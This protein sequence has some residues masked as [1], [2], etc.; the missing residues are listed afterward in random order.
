[1]EVLKK[2]TFVCRRPQSDEIAEELTFSSEVASS[3]P[4]LK[5][6][7][8]GLLLHGYLLVYLLST[9][10][11]VL[12][13]TPSHRVKMEKEVGPAAPDL[14]S[15]GVPP[16]ESSVVQRWKQN[17]TPTHA[18]LICLLLT[19]LTGLCDS[20]AYNA[21]SCFLGMQTGMNHRRSPASRKGRKVKKKKRKKAQRPRN[22]H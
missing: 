18:D 20:S 11:S 4:T 14:E 8:S 1:M 22:T 12:R 6:R 15:S 17:L 2:S 16:K 21:W 10:Y 3:R 19:F 13:G 9:P 7:D 5:F